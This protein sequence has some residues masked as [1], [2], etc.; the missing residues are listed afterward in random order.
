MSPKTQTIINDFVQYF[1]FHRS[2][3][4]GFLEWLIV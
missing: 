2:E 4:I 3:V 1:R